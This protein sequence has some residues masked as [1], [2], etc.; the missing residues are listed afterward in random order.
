MNSQQKYQ[1]RFWI[2]RILIA[3]VV[4]LNLQAALLFLIRPGQFTPGFELSGDIGN[5]MIQGI[6]LLFVMWNIPYLFAMV[7]PLRFRTSHLEALMMQTIGVAGETILLRL[8]PQGHAILSSS[9]TRFIIFDTFDWL[10]LLISWLLVRRLL[11]A[12]QDK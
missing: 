4:F 12:N 5:A 10:L 7:H 8:V 6:G 9:V 2:S 11:P 1:V 3:V